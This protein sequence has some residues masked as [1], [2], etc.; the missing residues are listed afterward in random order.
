VADV[1][2]FVA[3]YAVTAEA[4]S[5]T[6]QMPR[7]KVLQ[8]LT[9]GYEH[10]L[11]YLPAGALL[12]NARGVHDAST[13]ELAVALALASLRHIP[14]FARAQRKH[15]WLEGPF[16]A[17]ADKHVLIVGYGSIGS[18]IERRLLP[19]EVAVTRV[20]GRARPDQ[21]VYGVE[22]LPHLLPEADVVMLVT[23]LTPQT[24]H[25]VDAA[26]LDR[27]RPGALLVNVARGGVV[28]TDAL[29]RALQAGTVRAAL[30][31]TD[32]EPLPAGHPLW[33]APGLLL[34]PHVGGNSSAF[35]PRAQRLVREQ[36]DRFVRGRPLANV[37]AGQAPARG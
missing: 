32:P 8:T 30:D 18:A 22:D 24:Y 5:V 2:F 23:P 14:E 25:L 7:L 9:A 35:L 33:D 17:L 31:V 37:V 6:A 1:D 16:P 36:V 3:P 28:D 15:Q 29:V 12:C 13:A 20:A 26:F 10:A 4:L 11:P 19:F 34:S 27:M 21:D